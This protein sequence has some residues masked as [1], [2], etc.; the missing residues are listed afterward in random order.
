MNRTRKKGSIPSVGKKGFRPRSDGWDGGKMIGGN[1][2]PEYTK[3]INCKALFGPINAIGRIP[4]AIS[5]PQATAGLRG[6]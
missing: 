4:A 1:G 2:S 3:N 6:V 5:G